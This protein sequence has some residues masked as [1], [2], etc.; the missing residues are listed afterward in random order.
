MRKIVLAFGIVLISCAVSYA[1]SVDIHL[2][3]PMPPMPPVPVFMLPPPPPDVVIEPSRERD[4]WFWNDN[5]NM[6]FYYD[7]QNRPHYSKSH[8]YLDDGRHFYRQGGNWKPRH[9]DR[10][11]HNGWDKHGDKHNDN[12]DR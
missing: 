6:W 10:G 8:V 9:E 2:G 3:L 1:G 7:T 5:R 11:K 4:Y 12:R